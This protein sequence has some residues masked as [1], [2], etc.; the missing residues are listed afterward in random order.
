MPRL[1]Q[2]QRLYRRLLVCAVLL[3][4][5]LAALYFHSEKQN[6]SLVEQAA[7]Q[8]RAANLGNRAREQAEDLAAF[9][10]DD[11]R[12]QLV[13]LGRTELLGDAANRTL[14]YFEN[15]PPELITPSTLEARASILGTLANV[16]HARG[17]LDQAASFWERSITLRK[18]ILADSQ[19]PLSD[20]LKIAGAFN[21]LSIP[22][23][24]AGKIAAAREAC[25]SALAQ[26]DTLPAD[27]ADPDILTARAATRFAL[28][29]CERTAGNIE[30]ALI[31][32]ESSIEILG[33][34]PPTS[35]TALQLLMTCH[36]NS[37]F[38]HMSFGNDQAAEESYALALEPARSL[39]QLEPENR[40]WQKEIATLLNNLGTIHDEREDF[41]RALPFLTEAL[42]LRESLVA[43]DPANTRWQLDLSNSLRNIASL[44]L[45]EE[46][47]EL[48]FPPARRSLRIYQNLLAREPGNL[49]WLD[50]MQRET[51]RFTQRFTDLGDE[52][53][54]RTLNEEA[55]LFAENL[56][57]PS[58]ASASWNQ[59]LSRLYN[60]LSAMSDEAPDS[61]IEARLRSTILRAENV[62]ESP[63]DPE[64]IYQLAA[65][66][67]DLGEDHLRAGNDAQALTCYQLARFLLETRTPER[68]YRRELLIDLCLR[69]IHHLTRELRQHEKPLIKSG[70]EW[71]Y[72]DLRNPPSADWNSESF[73]DSTWESGPAQLGYGDGDEATL[74]DFG[75]DP[76]RKNLT[77]WFRHDFTLDRPIGLLP[78]RLSLLC[79]DGAVVYLN[80]IE[81]LRQG[82]PDGPVTP[83][84]VSNLTVSGLAEEIHHIFIL[85]PSTLPL[86]QGRNLIAVEVHQ[87]E[88]ASSDI[89][90]DLELLPAAPLPALLEN[91]KLTEAQTFLAEAI[92]P[93]LEKWIKDET[94]PAAP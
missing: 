75:P 76:L 43:W 82:I 63:E 89:S 54:A 38:C 17:D 31:Y 28:G 86:K 36:N 51:R 10:L 8:Q 14:E 87:N 59:F 94:V 9:M 27:T 34:E 21:E 49:E 24:E 37:G 91:F 41:E 29:D 35:I 90:F 60:D 40:H 53:S 74:L 32:Y 92:P 48:A 2:R 61:Q 64:T 4:S 39:I 46:Q 70:T 5:L 3:L 20:T 68:F 11:L 7:T 33:E 93:I 73:D 52:K 88:A 23:L 66:F 84:T 55:R 13:P 19:D 62:S 30:G 44:H 83:T 65:G 12:D 47:T 45:S 6:R 78:L 25:K 1:L 79:D 18:E 77:V 57:Q 42:A 85:D 67:L 72:Y 69:R 71:K 80:G 56:D 81:I 16:H 50:H 58:V 15:L 26:L 22:L